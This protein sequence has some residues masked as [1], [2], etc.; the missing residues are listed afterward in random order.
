MLFSVEVDVDPVAKENLD[1]VEKV[2][3]DY[4]F[5]VRHRISHVEDREVVFR[6]YWRVEKLSM[7]HAKH[8]AISSQLSGRRVISKWKGRGIY[9]EHNPTL[10]PL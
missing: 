4:G 9:V 5:K 2:L 6:G 1:E 10:E 7:I 8:L 3:T